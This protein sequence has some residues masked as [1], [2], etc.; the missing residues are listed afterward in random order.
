[1]PHKQSSHQPEPGIFAGVMALRLDDLLVR[2]AGVP[3]TLTFATGAA[4]CS[5]LRPSRQLES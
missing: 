1:M 4:T 2:L 5:P 3:S